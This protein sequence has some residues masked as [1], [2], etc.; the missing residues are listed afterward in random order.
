MTRKR[1]PLVTGFL[2]RSTPLTDVFKDKPLSFYIGAGVCAIYGHSH[3][4]QIF[5]KSVDIT[6]SQWDAMAQVFAGV[7]YALTSRVDFNLGYRFV[8]QFDGGDVDDTRL[9]LLEAGVIFRF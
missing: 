8:Y 9:H 6:A 5:D 1:K 2:L 3:T 7:S 4:T